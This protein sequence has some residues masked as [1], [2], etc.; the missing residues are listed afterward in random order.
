MTGG[1]WVWDL[2]SNGLLD[3]IHTVWCIVCRNVD[4]DEVR[5]F[6]PDDIQSA[7]DLLS[8]AD[9]IIGHNIIGYDIP[10]LQIVYPEWSTSAIVTDTLILS[11]LVRGD[12]FNDDA[13]RNFT[14]ERFPKRL[15]GSHSLKAWG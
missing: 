9:E 11:R 4:T 7:L 6:G 2:E 14:Q 13:E 15:W 10:A 12:L 5:E 1:R 3:T 8:G